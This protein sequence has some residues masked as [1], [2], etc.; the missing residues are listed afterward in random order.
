MREKIINEIIINEKR[1]KNVYLPTESV[2]TDIINIQ[3]SMKIRRV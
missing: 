2:H 1:E 3:Q